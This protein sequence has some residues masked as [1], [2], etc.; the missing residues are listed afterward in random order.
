MKKITTLQNIIEKKDIELRIAKAKLAI[1]EIKS[2]PKLMK[3]MEEA[4]TC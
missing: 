1:L 3:K 4:L 2:N